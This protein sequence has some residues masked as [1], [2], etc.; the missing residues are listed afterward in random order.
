MLQ[1]VT[2]RLSNP[3]IASTH[4]ITHVTVYTSNHLHT[5]QHT[6]YCLDHPTHAHHVHT[7]TVKTNN[8]IVQEAS[9]NFHSTRQNKGCLWM[10]NSD[11]FIRRSISDYKTKL[12]LFRQ[13]FQSCPFKFI[14]YTNISKAELRTFIISHKSAEGHT[15][16][17][18]KQSSSNTSTNSCVSLKADVSKPR[19]LPG[20][21]DK[22]K[23]KSMWIRWPSASKRML[24]LCLQLQHT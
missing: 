7:G 10:V 13:K 1:P 8:F 2:S 5:P 22:M 20:D 19:F 9:L 4:H 21:V 3:S 11:W 6:R 17:S 23:P 14:F 15:Q 16:P 24:P 18:K 12:H